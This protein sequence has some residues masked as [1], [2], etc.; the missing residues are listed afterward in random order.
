MKPLIVKCGELCKLHNKGFY[1]NATTN[2]VFLTKKVV[3]EI[4]SLSPNFGAQVAFDGGREYYN[5]VK[6]TNDGKGVYDI[7]K[8]NLHYALDHGVRTTIRC[9]YTLD[10]LESFLDVLN[11]FKMY[12][13]YSNL[14]FSFNKVWQEP[15]GQELKNKIKHFR[16]IVS[17]YNFQSN[18][19]SF[20]GYNSIC[21]ADF[22]HNYVINYN[23]DL[24]KCTARDF[25]RENRIGYIG[26]NGDIILHDTIKNTPYFTSQCY[27]CRLLPICTICSQQKLETKNNKCPGID[28]DLE[29]VST[30]I[31][32]YFCDLIN[33]N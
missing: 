29:N 21:Y 3:D 31:K 4:I 17:N 5:R 8:K 22:T 12:W 7:V 14:R 18:I 13:G 6:Y 10:N 33:L 1:V 15:I 32:K 20:N 28:A 23:G 9:N 25:K 2:G 27:N 16:N 24:F 19:K 11:D 30:N 26:D